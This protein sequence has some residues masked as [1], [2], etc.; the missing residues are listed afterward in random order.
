MEDMT[1]KLIAVPKEELERRQQ[2]WEANNRE[3]RTKPMIKK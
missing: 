2:E 1:A 3:P